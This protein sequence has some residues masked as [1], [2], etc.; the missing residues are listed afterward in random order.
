MAVVRAN[1]PKR[2]PVILSRAET[3]RILSH[4][5][6]TPRL[7]ALLLYGAGLRVMECLTLRIH[8]V[9][10]D[11]HELLIRHG[12]GGKDRRS[13]LPK[14]AGGLLRPHLDRVKV[15]ARRD[16]AAEIPGVYLQGAIARKYP[17]AGVEWG[18]QWGFPSAILSVD[19][20]SGLGRRHHAHPGAVNRSIVA[21][22]KAAGVTKH[23]TEHS[24]RHA[25]ATHLLEGGQDIRTAQE[26]LGH[27][28]VS[29]TMIYTHALNKGGLGV[30]SPADRLLGGPGEDGA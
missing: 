18:W 20:R 17:D 26:L 8:D 13:V 22:V 3:Q 11:R 12:K 7:I 6:G 25:F 28:D 21:A 1:R 4:L 27:A 30:T 29:T 2:L 10:F 9:D 5:D 19:P 23:A 24:F 15:L 16:R 14:S